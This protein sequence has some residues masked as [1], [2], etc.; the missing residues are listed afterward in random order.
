MLLTLKDSYELIQ[1]PISLAF[2]DQAIMVIF[3]QEGPSRRCQCYN[4]IYSAFD[5]NCHS[6]GGKG[7]TIPE[8]EGELSKAVVKSAGG[9]ADE[10]D[11]IAYAYTYYSDIQLDCIM[12]CKGHRYR[13][14]ELT[15][16]IT[17]TGKS[18][19][20]CGLDYERD[21]RH[22]QADLERYK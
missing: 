9:M 2:M 6:C 15:N 21:Y 8:R 20:V 3:E 17:M 1:E 18:V 10:G 7:M 22:N 5:P 19:A 14:I 13:V 12:V 4:N 16:T 11:P